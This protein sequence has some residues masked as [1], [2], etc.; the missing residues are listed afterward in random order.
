M[1]QPEGR[2]SQQDDPDHRAQTVPVRIGLLDDHH[3]GQHRHSA[4]CRSNVALKLV[5]LS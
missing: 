5:F 3:P 1:G 4:A 2:K